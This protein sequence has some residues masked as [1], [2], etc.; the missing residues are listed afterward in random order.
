MEPQGRESRRLYSFQR[1]AV[2]LASFTHKYVAY[3]LPALLSVGAVGTCRER[4]DGA[5]MENMVRFMV[6]MALAVSANGFAWSRALKRKLER[7]ANVK[8]LCNVNES[9]LISSTDILSPYGE[10]NGL[11][12]VMMFNEMRILSAIPR[13]LAP[14]GYRASAKPKKVAAR[15]VARARR[16]GSVRALY[17]EDEDL[18]HCVRTL[19]RILPGGRGWASA[20]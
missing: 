19:R 12:V 10:M 3:L 17:G 5:A 16:C 8:K 14:V 4:E 13:P 1:N 15:K 7:G 11:N 9:F 6:D 20:N 18:R 2:V